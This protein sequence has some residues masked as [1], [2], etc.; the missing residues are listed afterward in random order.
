MPKACYATT[1]RRARLSRIETRSRS[2][3]FRRTKLAWFSSSRH[4][5]HRRLWIPRLRK[6]RFPPLRSSIR[7]YRPRICHSLGLP[8]PR[9]PRCELSD[10][11]QTRSRRYVYASTSALSQ[12]CRAARAVPDQP[13]RPLD[14]GTCDTVQLAHMGS[15]PS[16]QWQASNMGQT[17][18]PVVRF[19]I[20]SIFS[21]P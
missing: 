4:D 7:T 18:F 15:D 11:F 21:R 1:A 16:C 3:R 19:S 9:L 20:S 10:T 13:R 5:V 2:G 8:T 12:P 14:A 17:P 6:R